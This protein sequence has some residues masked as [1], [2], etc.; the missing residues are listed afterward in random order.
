MFPEKGGGG[1]HLQ[2]FTKEKMKKCLEKILS[3][4]QLLFLH[5]A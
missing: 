3:Y 5:S 2:I 4:Q 1:A